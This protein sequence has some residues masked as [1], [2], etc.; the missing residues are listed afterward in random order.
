[1]HIV[2]VELI[3]TIPRHMFLFSLVFSFP[4]GTFSFED[5]PVCQPASR[6]RVV[7]SLLIPKVHRHL[8]EELEVFSGTGT[9]PESSR[10]KTR[11]VLSKI[12]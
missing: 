3:L 10:E 6:E 4:P 1:M 12:N 5:N 7:Q 11:Q 2:F 9:A 8:Q